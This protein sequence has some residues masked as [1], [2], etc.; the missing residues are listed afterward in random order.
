M[1]STKKLSKDE[2]HKARQLAEALVKKA[3]KIIKTKRS[4]LKI[5]AYKDRQD[6]VTTID[7][8]IET[9]GIRTIQKH[10][11]HHHILSE[12]SGTI[13][14]NTKSE[15]TWVFDPL[16]GTKE[17]LRRIPL[18]G[19][20]ISLQS[21]TD[22]LV[23]AVYDPSNGVYSA[24]KNQGATLNGSKISVSNTTELADS[25]GFAYLPKDPRSWS[26]L[27]KIA[28]H[29]YRL[30]GHANMNLSNC[31]VAHGGYDFQ[32]ILFYKAKWWDIAPGILILEEAGG[33]V[34][35][36]AGVKITPAHQAESIIFSNG[37]VHDKLIQLLS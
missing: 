21:T 29:V 30:R 26:A 23:A 2:L 22:I 19:S 1:P 7:E 6:V 31:Y 32:A 16:D 11:P 8:A 3:G 13:L 25:L 15:L 36:I 5:K 28:Q 17:Y 33:K 4:Q 14:G 10:F 35:D 37:K 34:T 12:E 24:A 20:A 27:E 9:E 18:Y